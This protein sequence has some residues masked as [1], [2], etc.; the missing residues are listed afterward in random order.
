M[1]LLPGVLLPVVGVYIPGWMLVAIAAATLLTWRRRRA[2]RGEIAQRRAEAAAHGQAFTIA[3]SND[4]SES[5]W[6]GTQDGVDWVVQSRR[7]DPAVGYRRSDDQTQVQPLTRVRLPAL[8]GVHGRSVLGLA[9]GT[10]RA[11]GEASGL[12]GRLATGAA[13]AAARFAASQAFG[14]FDEGVELAS[15]ARVPDPDGQLG[16]VFSDAPDEAVT[17]QRRLAALAAHD[18]GLMGTPVVLAT[19]DRLVL[20][21]RDRAT[22]DA[23]AAAEA[24]TH[25]IALRAALLA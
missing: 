4:R 7:W 18:A 25:A 3:I 8:P 19:P 9:A 21:W 20:V 10:G 24:A 12:V 2:R 15:L 6:Q 5:T 17:L 23:A 1:D 11:S 14:R 16:L 22:V 13:E